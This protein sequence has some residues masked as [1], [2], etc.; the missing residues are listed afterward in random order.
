MNDAAV[1]AYD[2]PRGGAA[3]G[4]GG[5]DPHFSRQRGTGDKVNVENAKITIENIIIS[6]SQ[7]QIKQ[8][9]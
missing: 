3:I 9:N 4:A 2:E 1:T 7:L 5:H 6:V 8:R